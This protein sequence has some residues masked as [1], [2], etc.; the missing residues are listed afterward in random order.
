[1]SHI[2][3]ACAKPKG[4]ALLTHV[5]TLSLTTL[6]LSC[7]QPQAGTNSAEA[8]VAG[9]SPVTF[10][11]VPEASSNGETPAKACLAM[12]RRFPKP[13]REAADKGFIS[14][15]SP[16]SVQ[17]NR[18]K[19]ELTGLC[20]KQIH[21]QIEALEGKEREIVARLEQ[22]SK[23]VSLAPLVL[24]GAAA[25]CGAAY[26]VTKKVLCDWIADNTTAASVTGILGTSGVGMTEAVAAIGLET[27]YGAQYYAFLAAASVAEVCFASGATIEAVAALKRAMSDTS[28]G[29][30][31]GERA[32][33]YC[34]L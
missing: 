26:M 10:A 17:E 34:G 27:A 33:N 16:Q 8:P 3:N 12:V 28:L 7:K 23:S 24:V 29:A 25:T 30:N 11:I 5:A 14:S 1:M 4:A 6:L 19:L 15:P 31:P 18:G 21:S 20:S 13:T 9:E 32:L 22:N 2:R